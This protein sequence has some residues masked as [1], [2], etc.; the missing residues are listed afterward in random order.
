MILKVI[1]LLPSACLPSKAY[2]GDL[3]LDLYASE[4]C[5]IPASGQVPVGT[6]IAVEMPEGW[7][8]ILKDR[9]SLALKRIYLSAGVID[10]GYR[11]EIKAILRNESGGPYKIRRG[12]K[13]AQMVPLP[14]TDWK[15]QEAADLKGTDRN[16]NGFGSSG[17]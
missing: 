10:N 7:G 2:P 1:K 15:V 4:D 16:V 3:G 6:G 5:E 9:S 11:G 14:V 13:I 8:G 12:D 17:K